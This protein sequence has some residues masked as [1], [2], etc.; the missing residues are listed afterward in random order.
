MFCSFCGKEL[1]DHA[2]FCMECG[3]AL[4]QTPASAPATAPA[5]PAAPAQAPVTYAAASVP[6]A[7]PAQAPVTYATAA[8]AAPAPQVVQPPVVQA[9]TVPVAAPQMAMPSAGG[10]HVAVK[11]GGF[12]WLKWVIPLVVVIV[13][14]VLSYFVF[15][16]PSDEDK[17]RDRIET[18]NTACEEGDVGGIIDCFDRKTRKLY[19]ATI[20]I[21]EGL[22]S[23]ITDFDLPL[24]D[25]VEAFGLPEGE[26]EG[27]LEVQ[28]ISINGSRAVVEVSITYETNEGSAT[29]S[30][31]V[32]MIKEDSDWYIDFEETT[33][34][35]LSFY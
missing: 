14:A 16:S 28:S 32:Y 3:K 17:I 4:P 19:D 27:A 12:G 7:Y 30:A 29:E 6:A 2:A 22:F 8:P 18:F 34:E 23:A 26:L 5:A 10:V 21:A 31:T 9:P 13:G 11:T 20:G 15:F 25:L 24:G 33:G 35:E 1:P